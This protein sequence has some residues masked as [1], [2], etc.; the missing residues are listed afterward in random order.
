MMTDLRSKTLHVRFEEQ[1]FKTPNAIA[2]VYGGQQFTYQELNEKSNQLAR[3]LRRHYEMIGAELKPDT[4]I[5]ICLDRSPDMVIG[6]LGVLKAGAAYVPISPA[7]PMERIQYILEDTASHLLLTQVDLLVYLQGISGPELIVFDPV[8]YQHESTDNLMPF[9]A[10][11]HLA[12]VIYTSGTTGQAKGVTIRHES[13]NNLIDSQCKFFA[14]NE[15]SRVLQYAQI[16]FDASVSELFTALLSGAAL[17]IIEDARRLDPGLLMAFIRE[18]HISVATLPPTLLKEMV[19]Q[20]LPSLKTLIVAGEVCDLDVMVQWSVGRRLIN[21]YGPTEATVCALMY[22]YQQGDLNTI[23]GKPLPNISIYILDKNLRPVPVGL[24]GELYIGGICLATGY[25]NK[26]ELTDERFVVNRYAK[27]V[28]KKKGYTRLYKTG[29]LAVWRRDGNIEYRGRN[30]FQCKLYGYRIELSEIEAIL[31]AFKGIKA[32]VVTLHENGQAKRLV[33]YYVLEKHNGE[34]YSTDSLN[35]FLASKLPSYMIPATY[36]QVERFPLTISGKIDRNSLPEPE[37]MPDEA[38]YIAPRNEME[39]IVC[40]IWQDVLGVS[41]IGIDDEFFRIGGDSILAIQVSAR[42][43]R[44]G[45]NCR[46]HDIFKYRT[47]DRL[48]HALSQLCQTDAEQGVLTGVF[49]LLPVQSCFFEKKLEQPDLWN[50]SFLVRVPPLSIDK[51]QSLLPKLVEHHDMMRVCFAKARS[52]HRQQIYL[53]DNNTPPIQILDI[54]TLDNVEARDECLFKTL[55][56]WQNAFNIEQGPLW[57][58]G[59]I[60]GYVDGSARLYIAAHHLIMDTVSWRILIDDLKRLYEHDSLGLKSSSYRQWVLALN[61]YSTTHANELEYWIAQLAMSHVSDYPAC[62]TNVYHAPLRLEQAL[63][64]QFLGQTSEAYHTEINDLLLTALAYTLDEWLGQEPHVIT[65]ESHGREGLGEHVDVSRTMGWFTS[66]YPVRLKI[67]A[68]IGESIQSVKEY[69]RAIPKKGIGFGVFRQNNPADFPSTLP[70]ISFNYLGQFD[71]A[72]GYWQLANEFSGQ[73]MCHGDREPHLLSLNGLVVGGQLQFSVTTHVS[74]EV[75]TFVAKS[76]ERN[77]QLIIV[78]CLN[79]EKACYTPS[80]FNA[81]KLSRSLLDALQQNDSNIESIYPVNGLQ[82]GFIYHALTQLDDDAYRG[83]LLLDYDCA[84]NIEAYKKAWTLAIQTYPVL[85]TYFN[86]EETLIQITTKSVHLDFTLYDLRNETNQMRAIEMILEQDRAKAFD[87]QSPMLLRLH[88]FCRGDE[89]YSLLQSMHHS[90]LDGWS[91]PVLLQKVHAYYALFAKNKIPILVVD[92]AY[93][94]AQAYI[95]DHK[96]E[97]NHYWQEQMATAGHANDLSVFLSKPVNMA[98]LKVVNAPCQISLQITGDVYAALKALVSQEGITWHVLSQFAWHKLI[99]IYTHDEQTIVGT[100]VSGRTI[101]VSGIENSVG[102]YINSLP[103]IVCWD[104]N[105]TVL[106]HLHQIEEHVTAMSEFSFVNLVDLQRE[107]QRLFHSTFV[108]ENYP[109]YQ[110]DV[111]RQDVNNDLLLPRFRGGIEKIDYPLGLFVH[112]AND[113]LSIMLRYDGAYLSA[114]KAER[115]LMQ[116]QLILEQLPRKLHESHH[117]IH[118]LTPDDHQRIVCDWNKTFKDYPD[119]KTMYQLFEE[120]VKRTPNNI[121]VNCC[122]RMLTY[123]ELNHAVNILASY[124]HQQGVFRGEVMVFFLSRGIDYLCSMLAA[125]KLGVAFVPLN[126]DMPKVRNNEILSQ[127]QHTLLLTS[128]ALAE[129]AITLNQSASVVRVE[130][131][132][133]ELTE[134]TLTDFSEVCA[135]DLAYIIFTSGSTGKPKGAMIQHDGAVNHVFAKIADFEITEKDNIAQTAT[136]TFDVSIWQFMAALMVGGRVTIFLE[137]NAWSPECLLTQVDSQSISILESVP[138][139]LSILVDYLENAQNR[140]SLLSLRYLMMNGEAL[141]PSYCERWFHHYPN[142]LMANVYGPTE[143]SDDVTHF[144]FCAISRDWHSYVPIGKPIQNMQVYILDKQLNPVPVGVTGELYVGGRGVGRGYLNLVDKTR[145]VFIA[146]PFAKSEKNSSTRLYKTG[147]WARWNNDGLIEYLGRTDFQVKING[148][149]IELGEVEAILSQCDGIKSCVVLVKERMLNDKLCQQLVAYYTSTHVIIQNTIATHMARYFPEYMIPSLFFFIEAL[150]LNMNGKIDRKALPEPDWTVDKVTHIAPRDEL[151][152]IVCGIWQATLNLSRVSIDDDFFRLGGHSILAIQVAHRM[153]R[154]TRRAVKVADIFQH[155]TIGKLCSVLRTGDLL[156]DIQRTQGSQ[157]SLSFSQERLWFIEQYERGTSAY[158]IPMILRLDESMNEDLLIEALQAVIMR[159]TILRT[160][161]IQDDNGGCLQEV[162]NDLV[163]IETLVINSEKN[164]SAIDEFIHRIFDLTREHPIR[165]ASCTYTKTKER[166]LLIVIH[167]IAFDEWSGLI[168]VKELQTYYDRLIAGNKMPLPPLDIQYKDFAV[169]QRDSLPRRLNALVNYWQTK[170][171]NLQP[172][173]MPTDYPRPSKIDYRGASVYFELPKTLVFALNQLT[174]VNGVTTYTTLLTGLALTLARYTGQSDLII[175]TPLANRQHPQLANLIGFFVNT[176]VLRLQLD[177]NRTVQQTIAAIQ[178]DL[179]DAQWHQ[180]LP[181]E[182]L[183]DCLNL[184]RDTSRSPVFQVMYVVQY[185]DE[186]TS[187]EI[188]D[189]LRLQDHY[190]VA[191]FDLT[192]MLRVSPNHISGSIQYA[193]SLF[194]QETM[195]RF[196]RHFAQLLQVMVDMPDKSIS[197]YPILTHEEYQHIIHDWNNNFMDYPHDATIHKLFEAQVR[198]TPNNI[199]VIYDEEQLTYKELNDAANQLAH[200]IR[201]QIHIKNQV[202]TSDTLIALCLDRSLEMVIGLL[203]I[204]KAGGAYVPIDPNQPV[205]RIHQLL[206]NT[207]CM[208]VLTQAYWRDKIQGLTNKIIT[209]DER[210]YQDENKRNLT[211]HCA[212]TDLAYVIFTSGSTGTPKGV[213]VSHR[214]IINTLFAVNA[215]IDVNQNDSILALSD[216]QFDLSVYDVFGTM[217]VGGTVVIPQSAKAKE[218]WYWNQ[219]IDT[220]GITLW[221]SV[222]ALMQLLL[223]YQTSHDLQG[224][225]FKAVLLSGDKIPLTLPARVQERAKQAKVLSLGGATE[226]TIWSI[227]YE[228]K[229]VAPHWM[230]IPYGRPMPNQ[231]IYVFDEHLNPCPMGVRGEIYIGGIGVA[232]GYWRDEHK[233]QACFIENTSF[234]RLYKTG[235]IGY[236]DAAGYVVFDGRMDTQVKLRGYRI[237]LA[238]IEHVLLGYLDIQQCTV[239]VC[240]KESSQYLVAY[241]VSPSVINKAALRAYLADYLPDYMLPNAFIQ[242]HD[243]PL[244]ANGKL[245]MNAL[246]V[247][248]WGNDETRLVAARSDLE[249]ALCCIWQDVLAVPSIGIQDNFFNLGGHSI[250]AIQLIAKM[251]KLFKKYGS[252]LTL[253]DLFTYPC[254][255]DYSQTFLRSRRGN[256]IVKLMNHKNEL[257]KNG[258]DTKKTIYF[259]HSALSGH[260]AFQ[261]LSD[262][263]ESKYRSIGIDNCYMF[264]DIHIDSLSSL[265]RYY[266]QQIE[267]TYPL[268]SVVTLCGWSLGGNIALEMAYQLEQRGVRNIQVFLLDTVFMDIDLLKKEDTNLVMQQHFLTEKSNQRQRL[269]EQG[270][271]EAYIE[272]VDKAM[273]TVSILSKNQLSGMLLHTKIGLFKA[274]QVEKILENTAYKSSIISDDNNIQKMVK[275]PMKIIKLNCSHQ[276]IIGHTEDICRV[277][278]HSTP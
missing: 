14:L 80:D 145:M 219:L 47:V 132:H 184:K 195:E 36:V 268:S 196:S 59:Y 107:S 160:H 209:L 240:S 267:S 236:W 21:A 218:P 72:S 94:N 82:Q 199:A 186:D 246:P 74:Q 152:T 197:T 24:V 119:D 254:I 182:K 185:V 48:M 188:N 216:V 126:P 135:R 179:I 27:E 66:F 189:A 11:H 148:Q 52:G 108:F 127:L 157:V 233:T 18:Q 249:M 63:T 103:L 3:H 51:L 204:L 168:F 177:P 247:P 43:Q 175:G 250:L 262:A 166:F 9:S 257:K 173:A 120:Q 5:S 271:D 87:L 136:Q 143:C 111:N 153:S 85:R 45:I 235:D 53:E 138:T 221:N 208:L 89:H 151:E 161:F 207:E 33:A 230:S 110:F 224:Y 112:Q 156:Q 92:H 261:D 23:I 8:A 4:L 164:N 258:G 274:M 25:L 129:E 237:E 140:P 37:W 174:Q 99:Q 211:S 84:I 133:N 28:D 163:S 141:S 91:C 171:D 248:E 242:P 79:K 104:I 15:Q 12:Y 212:A 2:I 118:L 180:D 165:A 32:S 26:P 61:T 183:V 16:V 131:G 86:W 102:M 6:I 194:K 40:G 105:N 231:M 30:D 147:D 227:W 223:D 71:T 109:E 88:L 193:T 200:F 10:A 130:D 50:Q 241:Y 114:P 117:A 198:R 150:P 232:L 57:Q 169:W 170:L 192:L 203:G 260:E 229:K 98:S 181:F 159:H 263:L 97:A 116:W 222:P 245:D 124:L 228:I 13:V 162:D 65:L 266:L 137:E 62:T 69:L 83:Q 273:D 113:V 167:H 20:A 17:I 206:I 31:N 270:V 44:A 139:H 49:A 252:S 239:L 225:A 172:L 1:A 35:E 100:T 78:H 178:N 264:F 22:E 149:R 220:H 19:H 205:A 38:G 146:N 81:V 243:F 217:M 46:V 187:N 115:L 201:R 176:L 123:Y 251:N 191:K 128:E 276:K 214:S 265:A 202:I 255:E 122:G 70:S 256:S 269:Q 121:A 272:Q 234:G 106:A 95:V 96:D 226:G 213:C 58:I 101:P 144:I 75:C 29:D 190:Q 275:R 93:L 142:V 277:I 77:L 210:P 34:V 90:I 158:H 76:F 154:A 7:Y 259:I 125:W 55:S 64:A 54:S 278:Y 41:Q 134:Q 60:H 253:S 215:Y 39:S 68:N 56:A 42:L 155:R 244:T 67:D 238:E 73:N